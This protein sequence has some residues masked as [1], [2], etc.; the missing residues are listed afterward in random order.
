MAWMVKLLVLGSKYVLSH[1]GWIMEGD[2]ENIQV[3][4]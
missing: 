2:A 1:E 4:L 3:V